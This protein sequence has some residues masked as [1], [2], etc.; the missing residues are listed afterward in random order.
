VKSKKRNELRGEMKKIVANLDPRWLKAASKELSSHL[1]RWI[2]SELDR[3][4][5]RILAWTSFFPGEVDLSTFIHQQL[6]K[7][8]VYLPRSLPDRSM[9]FISVN[10]DWDQNFETGYMGIPE[11]TG[12]TESLFM[13]EELEDCVIVVPGLAFDKA[14]NR[15]GRGKGYYDRFLSLPDMDKAVKVGVCWKL[16]LVDRVPT[17][18]HDVKMNWICHEE[19]M[20]DTDL[21]YRDLDG[22]IREDAL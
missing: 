9:T 12:V 18:E 10:N 6:T 11:P 1:C 21:A 16:Q 19:G 8:E 3:D 22:E 7:R 20:L 4:V 17:R 13:A 5:K 15:I 2:D 14:G